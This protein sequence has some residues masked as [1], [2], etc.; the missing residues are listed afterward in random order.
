MN[1]K[2]AVL[3]KKNN[4]KI[5]NLKKPELNKAQLFVKIVY[6]SICHTQLSEIKG[7]RGEDKFLPHCLGHEGVGIIIDKHKSVKKFKINDHVCLSWI[8]SKGREAGGVIYRD[9]TDTIINGGPVHTLNEFAVVSENRLYKLKGRKNLKSKVLLGCAL[10]TAYSA[11]KNKELNKLKSICVIGC[12]GLGLATILVAKKLGYKD[13]IA[14]DKV[15]RK[16]IAAKKLG[17]NYFF[18]SSDSLNKFINLE[19]VV[20]CTGNI[21]VLKKSI[22]YPKKFGGKFIFIGNY[23]Y[24]SKIYLDPWL[25]IQGITFMGAWNNS[26]PFDSMFKKLE[27]IIQ[28]RN[29]KIFFGNK[30]YNLRNIKK[31]FKDFKNGKVIRPLIKF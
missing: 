24:K 30:I 9:K 18:K 1:F 16:L 27:N 2:A 12:G 26:K 14:I 6:S 19:V 23:P 28:D 22:S 4:I 20:E 31:A 5:L 25:I 13:I 10:S 3:V 15:K 7:V 8:K 11:L 29:L 21:N 17:A